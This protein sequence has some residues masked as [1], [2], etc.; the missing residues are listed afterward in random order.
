[1][2]RQVADEGFRPEWFPGIT[3]TVGGGADPFDVEMLEGLSFACEG[4]TVRGSLSGE[5]DLDSGLRLPRVGV[6]PNLCA[7][8]KVC[9]E[10]AAI[11]F[12]GEISDDARTLRVSEQDITSRRSAQTFLHKD[13]FAQAR[14]SGGYRIVVVMSPAANAGKDAARVFDMFDLVSEISIVARDGIEWRCWVDTRRRM[15]TFRA[16]D[17]EGELCWTLGRS[18]CRPLLLR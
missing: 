17:G 4:D 15:P 14:Q 5:G 11:D 9:A 2:C 6:E 7:V 8:C 12:G 16:I 3:Y 18:R 10:F 1:M 13:P